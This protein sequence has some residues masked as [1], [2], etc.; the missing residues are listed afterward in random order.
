MSKSYDNTIL[1]FEE[2][3]QIKKKAM[4][5]KTDSTPVEEPKDPER[6]AVFALYRLVAS[7][8]QTEAMA[9]RYRKGGTGYGDVK[10][11][12]VGLMTEYFAEAREKRAELAKSPDTVMDVLREG[13]KK[14]REIAKVTVERCREA[15]GML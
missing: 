6:C 1:I 9:E 11:V 12:L 10:K 2:P 5:I 13:G 4:R 3:S 7:E 14:A 8:E 15:V